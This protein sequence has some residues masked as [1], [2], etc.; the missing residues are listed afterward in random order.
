MTKT[1]KTSQINDILVAALRKELRR[2][3]VPTIKVWYDYETESIMVGDDEV[4]IESDEKELEELKKLP[5]LAG[6]IAV[7]AA[8]FN[9]WE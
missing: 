4:A 2:L 1:S 9:N 5:N 3:N 7:M 8:L 6:R